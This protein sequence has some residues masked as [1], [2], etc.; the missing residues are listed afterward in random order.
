M[1]CDHWWNLDETLLS[2]IRRSFV[3]PTHCP[4]CG[5]TLRIAPEGVRLR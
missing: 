3:N 5:A 4:K 2:V 1:T